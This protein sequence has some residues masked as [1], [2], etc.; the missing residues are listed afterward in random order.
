MGLSV[1]QDKIKF[2]QDG[3]VENYKCLLVAQEFWQ[4][5]GVH[6][7]DKFSPTAA[8]VPIQVF[9]TMAAAKDGELRRFDAGQTFLKADIDE[10]VYIEVHE[11]SHGIL[12]G[13][14]GAHVGG[15][16]DTA[17]YCVRGTRCG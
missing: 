12:R 17:G 15:N 1:L 10:D 11:E 9:M 8:A 6:Y 2:G 16:D 5:E 3:E 14:R 13:S 4:A 7:S